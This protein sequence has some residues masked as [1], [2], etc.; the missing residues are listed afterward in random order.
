MS[1]TEPTI[2]VAVSVTSLLP[3]G[4]WLTTPA[5]VITAALVDAQ[6]IV[7]LSKPV[8]A[9]V[10]FFVTLVAESPEA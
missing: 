5:L 4:G 2:M 8:A 7:L 9:S 10:T 6:P 3:V 1:L